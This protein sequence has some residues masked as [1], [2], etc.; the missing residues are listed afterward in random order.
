[1]AKGNP[2]VLQLNIVDLWVQ[3]F[4]TKEICDKLQC[5]DETVRL[6]RKNDEL[7]QIYFD[8]QRE[9]VIDLIPLAVKR[10]KN[11]LRDDDVQAT[12]QI[13]AVREVFERAHLSELTDKTDNEIKITVSYE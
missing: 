13:A 4:S 8:R 3:G 11:I 12:A 2:T 7:K 1:M 9:Q 10:L 5:S 6:V